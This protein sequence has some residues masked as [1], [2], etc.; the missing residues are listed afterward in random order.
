MGIPYRRVPI[1]ALGRDIY[2]DTFLIA[3]TLDEFYPSTPIFV[4]DPVLQTIVARSYAE[5][6][7]FDTVFELLPWVKTPKALQ[8]DRKNVSL[9]GKFE[10]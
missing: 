5:R 10:T 9:P 2:I 4:S 6:T 3:Q 7:L 1:L 8:E